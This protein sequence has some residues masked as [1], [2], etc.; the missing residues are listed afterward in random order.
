GPERP[1][2]E[3]EVRSL[4]LESHVVFSGSLVG[5]ERER[6]LAAVKA[7][8]VPSV[9]ETFGLVVAE[10][11]LRKKVLIVSQVGAMSEVVGNAGLTFPI[12]DSRALAECLVQVLR[13]DE[14]AREMAQHGAERARS[15]FTAE[16][17]ID[18]HLML[19]QQVLQQQ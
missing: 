12:G 19:Y 17:M 13:S 6:A 3:D 4:R 18:A 10:S 9:S 14:F 1:R 5:A 16:R 7:I 2:L 11:M 8:I 15:L